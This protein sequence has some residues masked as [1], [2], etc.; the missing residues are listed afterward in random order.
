MICDFCQGD[1]ML[2]EIAD[3]PEDLFRLE[4][5]FPSQGYNEVTCPV[6]HGTGETVDGEKEQGKGEAW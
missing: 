6:C 5:I 2:Y 4:E 1:G 3:Y